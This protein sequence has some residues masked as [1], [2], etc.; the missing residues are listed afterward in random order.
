MSEITKK[1]MQKVKD[2]ALKKTPKWKFL[3]KRAFVWISLVVAIGLGAFSI[4]MMIFHVASVDWDLV[5]KI[6]PGP[7]LGLMKFI[8]YFWMIVAALL[9]VFVYFDFRNTR[10]GYRYS[11][12]LIV[13]VGLV[14]SII[15][16][17]CIYCFK[18]PEKADK[19]LRRIPAYNDMHPGCGEF[20]NAPEKGV[21][22]GTI[23]DIKGD[24]IV[25]LEDLGENTWTV[26]ISDARVPKK[27]GS[28]LGKKVKMVGKIT[29]FAEFRAKEI[30]PF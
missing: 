2:G 14:I 28:F 6:A 30:R 10:K 29:G 1:I 17:T 26:N 7:S 21:L 3:I 27:I 9:F 25:I 12:T 20:W 11:G 15:C 5:P 24:E 13:V 16:G 22:A 19:F 23:I 8:P 18:T 4:S